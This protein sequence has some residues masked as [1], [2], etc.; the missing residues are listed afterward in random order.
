MNVSINGKRAGWEPAAAVVCFAGAVLSLAIG[1]VF[2]T[3]DGYEFDKAAVEKNLTA[4]DRA[5]LKLLKE[6]RGT[7]DK[8]PEFSPESIHN[9]IEQFVRDHGLPNPGPIAQPVRV[10]VTGSSV[11]P[12]LGETLAVLGKASTLKRIDRCLASAG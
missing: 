6:F 8:L 2:T 1:F 12:G 7:L 5:G 3:D 4:N 11:S 10:A 9:A